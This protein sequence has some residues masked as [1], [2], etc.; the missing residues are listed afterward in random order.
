MPMYY[1][2][3]QLCTCNTGGVSCNMR[4]SALDDKISAVGG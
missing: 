1:E 3:V 4:Y 2:S